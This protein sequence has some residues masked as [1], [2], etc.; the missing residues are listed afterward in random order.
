MIGIPEPT[1]RTGIWWVCLNLWREQVYNGCAW[2][3]QEQVYDRCAWTYEENRYMMGVPEPMKRTGMTGV[4][5]P[6]KCDVN[7]QAVKGQLEGQAD[8]RYTV[9]CLK[10]LFPPPHPYLFSP[11]FPISPCTPPPSPP[12]I[13]HGSSVFRSP[14]FKHTFPGTGVFMSDTSTHAARLTLVSEIF[15]VRCTSRDRKH[16]GH[17]LQSPFACFPSVKLSVGVDLPGHKLFLVH[18]WPAA[19]CWD[20][21]N[22]L[23]Y[24]LARSS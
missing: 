23:A 9:L 4:P 13:S 12:S 3:Y 5:G 11:P 10:Y 21:V 16:I 22:T 14:Q 2:T 19:V 17:E 7:L 24:T 18:R 8:Q 20:A 6:T 1:N 15:D